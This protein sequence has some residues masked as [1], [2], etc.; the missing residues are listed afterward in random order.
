MG[1]IWAKAIFTFHPYHDF[2]FHERIDL[3][4]K[5]FYNAFHHF[6]KKLTEGKN[7]VE[8]DSQKEL[9]NRGRWISLIEYAVLKRMSMSTLRR[10]IR[11]NS[12]Q[13]ELRNRRYFIYDESESSSQ[14]SKSEQIIADLKEQIADLKTLVHVLESA[15]RSS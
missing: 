9:S 11:S 8:K 5:K 6:M 4:H 7:S 2:F 1:S 3:N 13:Y 14:E 12:I 10:R 15:Q